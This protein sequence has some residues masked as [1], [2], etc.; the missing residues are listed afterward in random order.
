MPQLQ[1]KPSQSIRVCFELTTLPEVRWKKS[2]KKSKIQKNV[3]K[4]VMSEVKFCYPMQLKICISSDIH[5]DKH[6]QTHCQHKRRNIRERTREKNFIVTEKVSN[7]KYISFTS[8]NFLQFDV[9]IPWLQNVHWQWL[10]IY[11][12]SF[13]RQDTVVLHGRG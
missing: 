13:P 6:P 11:W 1:P 2:P 7:D 5:E 12:F 4:Y 9:L 10:E 3:G 8:S